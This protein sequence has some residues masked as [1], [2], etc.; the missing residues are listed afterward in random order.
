MKHSNVKIFTTFIYLLLLILILGS[1]AFLLFQRSRLIKEAQ[2]YAV[3]IVERISGSYIENGSFTAKGFAEDV[4]EAMQNFGNLIQAVTIIDNQNVMQNRFRFDSIDP[5]KDPNPNWQNDPTYK[6]NSF[7]YQEKT[8]S[9]NLPGQTTANVKVLYEQLPGQLIRSV[10]QFDTV[11]I[12]ALLI[13]SFLAFL[14]LPKRDPDE[15]AWALQSVSEEDTGYDEAEELELSQALVENI[16]NLPED[17]SPNDNDDGHDAVEENSALPKIT[18]ID[19]EDENFSIDDELDALAEELVASEITDAIQEDDPW[20]YDISDNSEETSN[21]ST[22]DAD[23]GDELEVMDESL[24]ESPEIDVFEDNPASIETAVESVEPSS[25]LDDPTQKNDELDLL[26]SEAI[27]EID[28]QSEE[29]T[30]SEESLDDEP[31]DLDEGL[32]ELNVFSQIAATASLAAE[33]QTTETFA[34]AERK[35]EALNWL[36]GFLGNDRESEKQTSEISVALLELPQNDIETVR[37][38]FEQDLGDKAAFM[39]HENG[40]IVALPDDNFGQGV[41][42]LQ[43]AAGRLPTAYLSNLKMGITGISAERHGIDPDTV[44]SEMQYALA[45]SDRNNNISIFDTNDQVFN[46]QRNNT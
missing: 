21:I 26:L 45:N 32:E 19:W 15:T 20:S 37:T 44:L 33:E 23:F 1:A 28:E 12:L 40:L 5:E 11:F 34:N 31:L 10:L 41:T 6:Y 8:Y 35:T 39:P 3:Q 42:K 29:A 46:W 24:D 17:F 14:V 30:S 25:I 9:L 13:L 22:D 2:S 43:S 16:E 7:L 18:E 38:S 4:K 27:Q 36:G